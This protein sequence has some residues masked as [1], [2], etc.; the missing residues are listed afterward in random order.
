MAVLDLQKLAPRFQLARDPDAEAAAEDD[1]LHA[2]P[3]V[4]AMFPVGVSADPAAAHERL[5]RSLTVYGQL[6]S[7]RAMLDREGAEGAADLAILGSEDE[8]TERIGQ[9]KEIGVTDLGAVPV[10]RNPDE[11]ERTRA[12]LRKLQTDVA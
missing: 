11:I 8:I 6:P 5:A 9:L 12:I 4:V 3:R 10:G 1:D 7:Y 2:V